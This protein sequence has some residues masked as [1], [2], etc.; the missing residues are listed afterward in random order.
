MCLSEQIN[1]MSPAG[2]G[3]CVK[4]VLQRRTPARIVYAPNYWQWFAH[5]QNHGLLPP[6][7]AHCRTQLDLIR[8]LGLDV[9]SRNIYADQQHGWFGGLTEEVWDGVETQEDVRMEGRDRV[10]TRTYHTRRDT[11]T[12]RQRYVFS[13]ST[14]VQETFTLDAAKNPLDALEEL[15]RARRWRFLPERYAQEQALV[16]DDGFVVAGELV[17]PLKVLLKGWRF[18]PWAMCNLTR[19]CNSHPI[20]F[21]SPAALAR[22]KRKDSKALTRFGDTSKIYSSGCGPTRTGSCWRPV[23]IPRSARRGELSSGFATH[24]RNS[25][26]EHAS[27]Q[28]HERHFA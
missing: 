11:L 22:S 1:A 23:A 17:S 12:E 13:D 16:G 28:H 27:C 26:N 25:H 5:H 10:I 14:L 24:G 3:E 19:Q 9:F 15:L 20:G 7:I 2:H 18:R 4:S 8:H 21:S 6:D